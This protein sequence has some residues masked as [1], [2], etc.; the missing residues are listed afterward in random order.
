MAYDLNDLN[1]SPAGIVPDGKMIAMLLADKFAEFAAVVGTCRKFA[2]RPVCGLPLPTA[3]LKPE[4]KTLSFAVHRLYRGKAALL[5]TQ[6]A[7]PGFV[8]DP[9]LA[10]PFFLRRKRLGGLAIGHH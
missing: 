8:G 5:G 4:Q 7:A 3:R 9:T 1:H 6:C 2:Y 10:G